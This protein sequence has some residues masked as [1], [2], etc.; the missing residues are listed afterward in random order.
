M[1]G[2]ATGGGGGEAAEHVPARVFPLLGRQ[3]AA[4][5]G[6]GHAGSAHGEAGAF[7]LGGEQAGDG[8]V[9][10]AGRVDGGQPHE[11]PE[12]RYEV[13]RVG[14]E[15][16]GGRHAGRVLRRG[17]GGQRRAAGLRL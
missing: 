15:V 16:G 7:E 6:G 14:V 10:V 5:Q 1:E 3:V 17:R 8:V 4:D 2:L 9:V 11:A 13:V 12:Q